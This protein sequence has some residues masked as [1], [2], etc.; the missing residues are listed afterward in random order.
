MWLD[1]LI[2]SVSR[3]KADLKNNQTKTKPHAPQNKNEKAGGKKP[4]N[5]KLIPVQDSTHLE[6]V[7]AKKAADFPT[8]CNT[9]PY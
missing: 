4:Q 5:L 9:F 3:V 2:N 8:P 1:N 6:K 7:T